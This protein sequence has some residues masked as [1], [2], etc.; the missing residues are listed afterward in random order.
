MNG[1]Q[2]RRPYPDLLFDWN[3]PV[4]CPV[5]HLLSSPDSKLR[6]QVFDNTMENIRAQSLRADV[7]EVLVGPAPMGINDSRRDSLPYIMIGNRDMFLLEFAVGYFGTLDD[8][9][10]VTKQIR[11]FCNRYSQAS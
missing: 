5:P 2:D 9:K 10:I 3:E 8:A 7:R 11:W 6:H 1:W 4:S